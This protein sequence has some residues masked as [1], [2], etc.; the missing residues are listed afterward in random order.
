MISAPLS[1]GETCRKSH[2]RGEQR[3]ISIHS[4]LTKRDQVI[5]LTVRIHA[6]SIHSPLTRG[7]A[8][9][10]LDTPALYI[11]IHSPLTRGDSSICFASTR[12][13]H[14][15]PLPSYEGR[16]NAADPCMLEILFQSTPLIRGE[17]LFLLPTKYIAQFQST[18][19]IRGETIVQ[20]FQNALHPFQ[21]TPLIR[22][23]TI[24]HASHLPIL[25]IFQST[26]LIRGETF[27][28]A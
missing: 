22:G 3:A 4:S 9:S 1:R 7:D 11:S 25:V 16:L 28:R 10:S 8:F 2:F 26:P 24:L 14:F 17:T 23:E 13:G 18:P 6:I 15:N 5:G 20:P 19:L 27:P 12:R 21:S